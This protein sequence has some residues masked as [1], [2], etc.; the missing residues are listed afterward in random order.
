MGSVLYVALRY[1]RYHRLRTGILVAAITIV[2]FLPLALSE[3][4]DE[5]E[6]QLLARAESTPLLLGSRGSALDLVMNSLYF[7]HA[8]P[9]RLTLADAH[10]VDESGLGHAIPLHVLFRAQGHPVVGTSLEYFD[11]RALAIDRGESLA[12]LGDCVL[13]SEVADEFGLGPGDSLLTTPESVFDVAGAYPLKMHVTGVLSPS[14]TADDAAVFVDIR[15]AWVIAGLG[16]G[17][18]NLADPS[19]GAGVTLRRDERNVVANAALVQYTEINEA[20]IDTFHFHGASEGF[21][22]TGALVVPEGE[23]ERVLLLG[24]YLDEDSATQLVEPREAITELTRQIFKLQGF[25]S[26]VLAV[27]SIATLLTIFLVFALSLRLRAGELR[28]MHKL[29]AGRSMAAQLVACEVAIILGAS[30]ILGSGLVTVG[31]RYQEPFLRWM[32]G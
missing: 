31:L 22:L 13:G 4:V 29:G 6:R 21:P 30:A 23:R 15:T 14:G 11:H 3:L 16:H 18:Q 28:T 9:G 20:N 5:S 32:A 27:A 19:G 1:V 24:R 8:P 7:S 2:A 25:T 17:H 26:A 10:A 12:L